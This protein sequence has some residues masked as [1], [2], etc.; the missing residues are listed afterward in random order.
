TPQGAQSLMSL[1]SGSNLDS[2]SL[3]N[4]ASLFGAGGAGV[5][6]LLQAGTS[7]LVP[8]LFG[9]KGGAVVQALSGSSGIK[10]SS[11]TNLIAMVVPLV[12]VVLKKFIG[13]KGLNASSLSSLLASQGPNLQGALDSRVTSA[14][15]FASPA[16]FLGG[17]GGET[18]YVGRRAGDAV[19]DT[20]AVAT[21][22]TKSGLMRWLPWLIGAV[23]LLFL[24]NL[25]TGKSTPT[26]APAPEVIAAP[27]LAPM[28]APAATA[29]LAKVYFD[30]GAATIAVDGSEKIAAAA[31]MIRNENLKVALTGY[32]DR[33]GDAMKNEELAKSRAA[34]VRDA[35]LAAGVADANIE[36]RAPMFVEVGGAGGDA[37][38]RRVDIV[39]P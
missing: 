32:T 9:D 30:V 18:A 14:L 1:I 11:A 38:A 36:M 23:A 39:R 27:T 7:S 15:G 31:G 12:M 10:G 8:A 34:A 16:A 4:L 20:A 28:P 22:A 17:L 13:D 6:S 21:T 2:S 26:P 19:A 29:L 25:L 33:T 5:S 24:W 3:G 37:E 35:L